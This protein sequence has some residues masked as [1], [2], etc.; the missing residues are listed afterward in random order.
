V[1]TPAKNQGSCAADWAFSATGTTEGAVTVSV[2]QLFFLSEQQLLDCTPAVSSCS[3]SSPV[4]GLTYLIQSSNAG[5][6]AERRRTTHTRERSQAAR[7]I[8]L[9]VGEDYEYRSRVRRS[10]LG[11]ADEPD[12]RVGDRERK[13]VSTYTGGLI[14]PTT[15]GTEPPEYRAVLVVGYTTQFWIVKNSLGSNWGG[16]GRGFFFFPRG[17]NVCGINNYLVAAR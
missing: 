7:P 3:D 14:N 13:L 6:G 17:K 10:R 15:C 4:R 8:Q 11:R 16:N 2:G 5:G 12:A 9:S 1:V